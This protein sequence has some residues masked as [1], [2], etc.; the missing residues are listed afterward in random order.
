MRG[1]GRATTT[2]KRLSRRDVAKFGP[3]GSLQFALLRVS[4]EFVL[5][6]A[7]LPYRHDPLADRL[8]QGLNRSR[9]DLF[10]DAFRMRRD[11]LERGVADGLQTL[12]RILQTVPDCRKAFG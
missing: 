4:R 9:R 6:G 3:P 5:I 11:G 7:P 8:D 12:P 10:P 1:P 2:A